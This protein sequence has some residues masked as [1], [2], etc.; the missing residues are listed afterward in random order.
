[1]SFGGG[2]LVLIPWVLVFLSSMSLLDGF[3]NSAT[4]RNS[5][6]SLLCASCI[7]LGRSLDSFL[8]ASCMFFVDLNLL[9][10]LPWVPIG[11]VICIPSQNVF[12]CLLFVVL[13]SFLLS[14]FLASHCQS[15]PGAVSSLHL[16]SYSLHFTGL[17]CTFFAASLY[18]SLIFSD[19]FSR[20]FRNKHSF[21]RLG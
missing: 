5:L 1:M 19:F 10:V 3:I 14:A 15:L 13:L 2:K 12:T 7:V 18:A 6:T 20:C 8:L 9:L 11:S 16:S 21:Y 17:Q 4:F